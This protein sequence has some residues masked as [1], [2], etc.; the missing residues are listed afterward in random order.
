MNS[1]A[2]EN[3]HALIVD[4]DKTIR[5]LLV[6]TLSKGNIK[7]SVSDNLE[8]NTNL[9]FDLIF[10]DTKILEINK[11]KTSC[12]A[13]KHHNEYK[14]IALTFSKN[15][16][17]LYHLIK[18]GISDIM[19]KPFSHES[20]SKIIFRYQEFQYDTTNRYD[21]QAIVKIFGNDKD[22]IRKMTDLYI[23]TS[24]NDFEI[25]L[26]TFKNSDITGLREMAHKM[27][28]PAGQIGAT[29]LH[30]RFK[31]M[32]NCIGSNPNKNIT[33]LFHRIADINF[34]IKMIHSILKAI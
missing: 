25:L 26:N 23:V 15:K 6:D 16:E 34:E 22:F 5:S 20:I 12:L 29:R 27:A 28:S 3:L 11:L 13:H 8:E 30:K 2:E 21:E 19:E 7:C 1:K 10:V 4:A 18:S 24:D 17:D 14:I 9:N 33:D 31:D 32:E